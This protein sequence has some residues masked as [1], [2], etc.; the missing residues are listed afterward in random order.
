[1]LA[2]YVENEPELVKIQDTLSLHFSLLL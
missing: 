1:M 2:M